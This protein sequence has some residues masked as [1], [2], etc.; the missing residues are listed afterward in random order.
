MFPPREV[1]LKTEMVQKML[2]SELEL[3]EQLLLLLNRN[4][5]NSSTSN[6]QM[7][8]FQKSQVAKR[9]VQLS[10]NLASLNLVSPSLPLSFHPVVILSHSDHFNLY[11]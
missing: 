7:G 9:A 4:L 3:S 5:S 2:S 8:H 10:R 11:F 6:D 1:S